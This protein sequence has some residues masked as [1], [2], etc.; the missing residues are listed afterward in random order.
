MC[1]CVCVF[2]CVRLC[3]CIAH[4]LRLALLGSELARK[5]ADNGR[6]VKKLVK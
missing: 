4:P 1:V 6:L 5:V 3:E 2:V